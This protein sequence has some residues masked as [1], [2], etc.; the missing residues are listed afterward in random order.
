MNGTESADGQGSGRE[1]P[2]G[3]PTDRSLPR[4]TAGAVA[5]AAALGS[6][7]LLAVSPLAGVGTVAG[8]L[9]GAGVRRST[10]G[11]RR[12][13]VGS[14]LLP[15]AGFVLVA[16]LGSLAPTALGVVPPTIGVLT[17][18]AT[19]AALTDI[20][21]RELQQVGWVGVVGAAVVGGVALLS[22]GLWSTGG[23]VAFL[24]AGVTA[25]EEATFWVTLIA[26]LAIGGGLYAIPSAA[27][28]WSLSDHI[29]LGPKAM[30]VGGLVAWIL[31]QLFAGISPVVRL[32]L[33]VLTLLF[34][35]VGLIGAVVGQSWQTAGEETK[36]LFGW[37]ADWSWADG[38]MHNPALSVVLSLCGGALLLVAVL[39]S[40]VGTSAPVPTVLGLTA[41]LLGLGGCVALAVA[42][43]NGHLPVPH[44]TTLLAG[45]LGLQA[46]VVAA[47]VRAAGVAVD[48]LAALVVLTAALFVY[49]AGRHGRTLT[50]EVG[51]GTGRRPQ[52][53]RLGWNGVVGVVGLVVAAVLYA[54]STAFTP[55]LAGPSRVGV[56]AGVVALTASTW[57][58]A[59]LETR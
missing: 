54:L 55:A 26:V 4:T 35:A 58:Y 43:L 14:A 30:L 40:A 53:V 31:L 34:L 15:A 9:F 38:E 51:A 52:L 33:F 3:V 1:G 5:V 50:R 48:G 39:Y 59:R 44:A 17:G 28:T 2:R 46:A 37:I 22:A 29:K 49:G 32:L 8:V 12:L 56:L 36:P 11:P 42:R 20:P 21:D 27:V 41:A 7:A 19:V 45:T 16:G 18:V 23:V 6:L 57:L 13:V 25:F 10:G 47:G 24:A